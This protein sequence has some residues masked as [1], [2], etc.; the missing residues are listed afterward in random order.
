M[1][2]KPLIGMNSSE[3]P[4]VPGEKSLQCDDRHFS[5]RKVGPYLDKQGGV[6]APNQRTIDVRPDA[7]VERSPFGDRGVRY[8]LGRQMRVLPKMAGIFRD[9]T[10]PVFLTAD[11][12]FLVIA[13]DRWAGPLRWL[14]PQDRE[15]RSNT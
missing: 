12:V 6:R 7:A 4:A 2:G 15:S 10:V 5:G 3:K 13:I 14:E 1:F 8:C 11:A 9:Q